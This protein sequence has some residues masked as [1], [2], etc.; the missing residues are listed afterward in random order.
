MPLQTA[1]VIF[2]PGSGDAAESDAQLDL[3]VSTLRDLKLQT[4]VQ[5]VDPDM[6]IPEFARAAAQGGAHFIVAGGGD[7]TID[8][9][10]RGLVGTRTRLVIVPTGTR[11][12]IARAL[13]IPL[14]VAEATRLI[15]TG[16]RVYA[17]MGRVLI[18]TREIYFLELVTVGLGAAM[19]PAMDDAQHGNLARVG[20]LLATFI[21][22]PASNFRLNLDHGRQ[23]LNVEAQTMVVL[24]MPFLGANFQIGSSVDWRDGLLDVFVYA[25]LG[26][27]D[28]LTHAVQ[29]AQG[30]TDDPRVRHLR[31]KHLE[32]QTDPALPVMID[33]EI[34]ESQLL[35]IHRAPRA[36][37]VMVPQNA[38]VS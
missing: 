12:N 37:R 25:D 15:A 17:D 21:T 1:Q 38:V 31:V 5:R 35:K 33:G 16:K 19:F 11:N 6:S 26:K 3:T 7:N 14:D 8:L 4:K 29:V 34:L 28:L 9:V 2:N 20:D 18:E 23:R 32:I 24:N 22:N 10:A 36:L 27:L 13:N 30:F